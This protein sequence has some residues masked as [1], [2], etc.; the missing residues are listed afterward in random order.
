MKYI[1]EIIIYT[2]ISTLFVIIIIYQLFHLIKNYV[3]KNNADNVKVLLLESEEKII[4]KELKGKINTD[5]TKVNVGGKMYKIESYRG[6][7]A[8]IDIASTT[9]PYTKTTFDELSFSS[10]IK[11]LPKNISMQEVL[12]NMQS[13][14][15]S[16]SIDYQMKFI[17]E[18][19]KKYPNIA[20]SFAPNL[21]VV[22]VREFDVDGDGVNEKIVTTQ[23]C[24][25]N[26]NYTDHIIKGENIIF[27]EKSY[28]KY[29][30]I[31]KS[32]DDNGF[33]LKWQ[34]P[35]GIF[36]DFGSCC[37]PGY[38]TTRFIFADDKFIPVSETET[39]F[40]KVYDQK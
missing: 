2:A 15:D 23:E 1:K 12:K 8:F 38:R 25:A 5:Q 29:V 30:N 37:A 4:F 17:E 7:Y 10:E 33:Y 39:I 35:D 26:C 11:K 31:N 24:G 18:G 3:V 9:K 28:Y 6:E 21:G 27:E 16:E 22:D 14:F 13:N 32:I 36:D 20:G 40:A 34:P 19:L